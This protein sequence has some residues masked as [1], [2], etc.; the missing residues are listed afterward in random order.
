VHYT[1]YNTGST[2][3]LPAGTPVSI[4]ADG[5]FLDYTETL[6]DIAIG[7]SESSYITLTIPVGIPL[8]F[9][10][11]FVADDTGDGTGIII[12]SD[13]T[14]NS[15]TELT[16]LPL[17]PVLQQPED[18]TACDSGFGAT[19]DFSAYAESLK[20]YPNETVTFYTTQPM[21][22]QD[23]DRIYDITNYKTGENPKRIYVRLD[24]G[25]CFT[26][27]SFLLVT[28]KCPPIPYNYV[29]P[30]GDGL[31]DVFFVENLRNVFLNFK[32]TI[33]NRWG[34]LVWTGD[35]ST[36]DWDGV[37]NERKVGESGTTVPAGTYYYVIELND[38]D[39]PEPLV[40]WVY[41]TM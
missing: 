10:L 23:L 3:V 37:A 24:N 12:E 21:A 4:Y 14:N 35:N 17:S 41:V 26:T 18:I 39:F 32:T 33:Y 9:N 7:E 29:T 20:N 27:A 31:N 5:Q 25:T 36:A 22:D 11:T 16:K 28:Q 40:G 8:D 30:N 6:E 15:D 1:V 38:P 2:D 13:E 34:A 19:F